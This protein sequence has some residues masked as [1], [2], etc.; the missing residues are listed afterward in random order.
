VLARVVNGLG[1]RG[2]GLE[3]S[4]VYGLGFKGAIFAPLHLPHFHTYHRSTCKIW[5][6]SGAPAVV[7][8]LL[9]QKQRYVCPGGY[10]P[11]DFSARGST[12]ILFHRFTFVSPWTHGEPGFETL[13]HSLAPDIPA[14]GHR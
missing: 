9:P 5:W 6:D 4:P 13:W 1:S 11:L 12:N 2:L 7:L 14:A 8:P 3:A 10:T